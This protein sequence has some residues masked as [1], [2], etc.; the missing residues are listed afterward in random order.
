MCPLLSSQPR[1][2][3]VG[4]SAALQALLALAQERY[5]TALAAWPETAAGGRPGV[6][7][8]LNA[9]AE[10]LAVPLVT[11]MGGSLHPMAAGYQDQLAADNAMSTLILTLEQVRWQRF[12]K[13]EFRHDKIC[14]S[15]LILALEQVQQWLWAAAVFAYLGLGLGLGLA[16]STLILA[17]EQV[18]QW[19]YL[20]PTVHQSSAASWQDA[21]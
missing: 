8:L 10:A 6:S 21:P 7:R 18:R 16:M 17:M 13:F 20:P 4:N 15:C 14:L 2:S 9:L 3:L 11:S 12:L 1:R 5:T 19:L